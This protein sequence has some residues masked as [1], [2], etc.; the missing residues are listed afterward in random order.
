MVGR[1][2]GERT[3]LGGNSGVEVNTVKTGAGLNHPVGGQVRLVP[4]RG[5]G[6]SDVWTRYWPREKSGCDSGHDIGGKELW[7]RGVFSGSGENQAVVG[8]VEV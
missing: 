1:S 8:S 7:R 5:S 4:E 2:G 3:H 6:D